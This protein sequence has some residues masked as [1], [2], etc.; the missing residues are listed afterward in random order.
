[1][2]ETNCPSCGHA[3]ERLPY[4]APWAHPM[5]GRNCELCAHALIERLPM[6]VRNLIPG[7]FRDEFGDCAECG[8]LVRHNDRGEFCAG[9]D[10]FD[11][12]E[13]ICDGCGS[14]RAPHLWPLIQKLRAPSRLTVTSLYFFLDKGSAERQISAPAPCPLCGESCRDSAP[15]LEAWYIVDGLQGRPLCERCIARV[16]QNGTLRQLAASLDVA[17]GFASVADMGIT[18]SYLDGDNFGEPIPVLVPNYDCSHAESVGQCGACGGAML[19]HACGE[20][21]LLYTICDGCGSSRAPHLWPLVRQRRTRS[22]FTVTIRDREVE[23]HAEAFQCPICD[24]VS[25][26]YA[27]SADGWYVVESGTGGRPVC[28]GCVELVDPRGELRSLARSLDSHTPLAS[29]DQQMRNNERTTQPIVEANGRP[30]ER[31]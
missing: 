5:T 29:R 20:F 24:N 11:R 28:G 14:A 8:G 15:C 31:A 1:M 7:D 23:E 21:V 4:G 27:P 16:D 10:D 17:C 25:R 18:S 2:N 19:P 6:K 9:P 22:P 26:D 3:I 30:G 13:T 12:Y